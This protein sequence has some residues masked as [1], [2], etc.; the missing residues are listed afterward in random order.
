MK[1]TESVL[2]WPLNFHFF[3]SFFEASLSAATR[4]V[5]NGRSETTV[6][7]LNFSQII[8][9]RIYALYFVEICVVYVK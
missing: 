4:S 7:K 6:F 2:L 1:Y 5:T 9:L 3:F 8:Y